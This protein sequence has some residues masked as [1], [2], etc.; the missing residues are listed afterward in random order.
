AWLD[1]VMHLYTDR[2]LQIDTAVACR[3]GRLSAEIG[4]DGADLLIAATAQEHGLTVVTR[5]LRHFVPTGVPA[6]NPWDI[7][8]E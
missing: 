4:N 2:I 5:N 6:L 3:W 1:K 8:S 7:P